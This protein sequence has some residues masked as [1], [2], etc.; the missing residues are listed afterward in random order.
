MVEKKL[1][2]LN[3][4]LKIAQEGFDREMAHMVEIREIK[5]KL[6]D[7]RNQVEIAKIE[8]DR[9][10]VYDLQT[11]IIPVYEAKLAE[12]ES[13]KVVIQPQHVAEVIS[14]LTGIPVSKLTSKENEKLIYMADRLKNR[15]FGQDEA[16][17]A[18]VSSIKASKIGLSNENKP[19]GSFLFLGPTGVGKTEL[20][21]AICEELNDS[22]ENMVF[23]DMSDYVNE[24]SLNKLIGAPA[25]YVGCEEGGTLTEP[26]KEMPYNVVLLDEVDL[27]HQSNLNILYQLLEE[28]RVTDGRGVKVS[29]K[30]TVIIMTSNLGQEYITPNGI[31][32]DKIQE[33]I[34]RRFGYPFV[35]R[36]DNVVMFNHLPREALVD[37]FKKDL[38]DLNNKL[39]AQSVNFSISDAVLDYVI[40]Y[41]LN[42][43]FGARILK[44]FI[45]DNF[46]NPIIEFILQ[47]DADKSA[48]I[49]CYL[50]DEPVVGQRY[51]DFVFVIQ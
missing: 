15:I 37:I 47:K 29:F 35:N 42:S 10:R 38:T 49:T 8:N 19:I 21:K 3:Q 11:N 7:A 16:I 51:G 41:S 44:R 50:C 46:M 4:E 39:N 5:K 2:E 1:G 22:T 20:S 36:I 40:N 12:H 31:Q 18:V 27:G 26:I 43:A 33:L 48:Q 24:I 45:K 32:R 9:Y 30:N 25:G 34:I 23:L 17:N 6:D 14:R 13:I 28:G